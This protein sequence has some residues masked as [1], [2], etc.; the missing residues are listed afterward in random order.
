MKNNDIKSID[1]NFD[2]ATDSPRYWDNYWVNED[3]MPLAE[4]SYSQSGMVA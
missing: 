2:F 4:Q 1:V 3:H